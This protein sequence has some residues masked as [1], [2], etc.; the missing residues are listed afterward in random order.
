MKGIEEIRRENADTW[1][2]VIEK[3]RAMGHWVVVEYTGT[4]GNQTIESAQ[5]VPAERATEVAC[6]TAR[7]AAGAR[8]VSILPPTRAPVRTLGEYVRDCK[9]RYETEIRYGGTD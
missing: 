9:A 7:A 4:A 8:T 6:S 3:L 5:A 1:R 2:M